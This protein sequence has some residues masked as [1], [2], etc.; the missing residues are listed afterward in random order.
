MKIVRDYLTSEEI[1]FIVNAMLEKENAVEREIVKIAL[2]MQIIGEDLGDFK[3]CNDIYDKVVADDTIVNLSSIINNYD[4]I[5]KLVA[6]ELSVNNIFRDFIK[7]INDKLD[8]MGDIDLNGAIA[9]LKEIA[10]KQEIEK[11]SPI[12]GGR[13]NGSTKK[14]Q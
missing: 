2:I 9:Q 8:K 12:K 11:I 6:E 14:V 7:D 13:K 4:V 10:D 1:S 5:D 3:D